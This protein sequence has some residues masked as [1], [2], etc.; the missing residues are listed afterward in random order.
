MSSESTAT[1]VRNEVKHKIQELASG[2]ESVTR[3]KLAILRHG[4][5]KQPGDDPKTW[6]MLFNEMPEE[7]M[8]KFGNP[9]KEEWAIYTAMT[10]YALHQQGNDLLSQSVYAENASL[11]DAARELYE[12]YKRDGASDDNARNQVDRYFHKVALAPDMSSMAYYLRRF[13]SILKA[14]GIGLDYAILAKDLYVYQMTGKASSIR[15]QWGQDYYK[16]I[17]K[18]R[19]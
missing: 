5:T 8:G 3:E 2:Q 9:S 4:N 18:E 15:L 13:I 14:K 7:M 17:N 16:N 19:E 1:R 12:T 11:G 6:G 10:L